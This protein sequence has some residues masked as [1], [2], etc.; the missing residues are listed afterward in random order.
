MTHATSSLGFALLIALAA[1][2]TTMGT[3]TGSTPGGTDAVAF[4]W[5]S[6]DSV[7]GTMNAMLAGGKTYSG[8][9]FQI[10]RDTRVDSLT[11]LWFGWHRGWAGF[12]PWPYWDAYPSTGFV[13][14]YSGRVVANLGDNDG[15]H[16]RCRFTLAH[17]SSGMAGGGVGQ[18]QMPDGKT[19]DAT[20][21]NA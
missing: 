3:G 19:V 2:C 10:T 6:S 16:M 20:F 15:E 4:N 14:S 17:P 13:T 5:K 8:R 18:C 11:P 7:S 9:F 21:P 12:G 1:G